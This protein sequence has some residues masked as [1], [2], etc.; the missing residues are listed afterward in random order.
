MSIDQLQAVNKEQT[1]VYIPY[2]QLSKRNLLPYALSLYQK[3]VLEGYRKIESGNNIPFVATWNITTLPSDL[4]GCRMQ[5]DGNPELTYEVMMA[6]FEFVSLL[7]ELLQNYKRY[8]Y[9]D[10]SPN[11]YRKLLRA[12]D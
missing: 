5:F 4:I 6:N 3:G 11:F 9:P 12:D 10:F 2:I 8:R 7:I 1:T